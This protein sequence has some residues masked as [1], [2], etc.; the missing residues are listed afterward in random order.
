LIEVTDS[1]DGSTISLSPGEVVELVLDENATT[2]YLW[3]IAQ[4]PDGLHLEDDGFYLPG[5][6]RPGAGGQHWFRFHV[7]RS[8]ERSSETEGSVEG[9]LVA[10]LRRPW[11]PDGPAERMF[12]VTIRD[13]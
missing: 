8:D 12:R 13:R 11:D 2:G 7:E 10:E 9:T 6:A 1:D 4:R 3:S 5:E